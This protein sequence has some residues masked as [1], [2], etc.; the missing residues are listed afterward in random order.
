MIITQFDAKKSIL[1]FSPKFFSKNEDNSSH[2]YIS[3]NLA[4][5][6]KIG[7]FQTFFDTFNR[8]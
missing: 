6:N 8:I 4:L 7:L 3:R 2:G 1:F 5:K